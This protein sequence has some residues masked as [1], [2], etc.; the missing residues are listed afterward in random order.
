MNLVAY[1]KNFI[2]KSYIYVFLKK[3]CL[4]IKIEKLRDK[5][6]HNIML[7]LT[8]DL[9]TLQKKKQLCMHGAVQYMH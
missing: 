3:E 4:K 8:Y 1:K 9:A 7:L 6:I 5:K 2:H